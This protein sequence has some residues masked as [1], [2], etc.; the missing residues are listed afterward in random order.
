MPISESDNWAT[1]LELHDDEIHVWLAFS[2]QITDPDLLKRYHLYLNPLEAK[3]Q[4]RFYFER[5]QHQYLVTR[6]FIRSLLTRYVPEVRPSMWTFETNKYGR[7]SIVREPEWPNLRFNISHTRGLISIAVVK[8]LEVGVDVEQ[9]TRDGEQIQIADR[10]FSKREVTELKSLPEANQ[11]DRFFDYWTLKES[12]IKAR[13]MGLSIP[14]GDF[15]FLL[16]EGR[17]I[18]IYID[19]K[20]LDDPERWQF[21]SWRVSDE[22]KMALTLERKPGVS[23]RLSLRKAVPLVGSEPFTCEMLRDSM[24]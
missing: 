20:Q 14:L 11:K 15:S 9:V 24:D 16:E 12:Y 7:P 6:G 17:R 19:P 10:F 5:D 13:G 22:H 23:F 8:D 3:K 1:P 18:G 2:N 21:R 4:K